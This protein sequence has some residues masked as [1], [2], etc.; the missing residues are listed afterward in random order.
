MEAVFCQTNR[1][2]QMNQEKLAQLAAEKAA[3][4]N[5]PYAGAF[6]PPEA[7]A[8]VNEVADSVIVDVRTR[9]ELN[10]V[11]RIPKAVEIEWQV[12]PEMSINDKFID[13]L[14]N[15]DI[16]EETPVMFICRSGVRSH[17][18][19]LAAHSAGYKKAFNILE[20]FE[21]DLNT[22]KQRSRSNGWRFHGLPW[23]QN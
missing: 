21:G 8:Y 23:H 16:H 18:A 17:H 9:P 3:K 4:L 22:D 19:A 11:G 6:T 7:L 13:E 1:T 15:I 12:W 20:G 14:K 5:L 2:K 10:Y